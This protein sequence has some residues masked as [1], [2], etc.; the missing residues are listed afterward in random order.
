MFYSPSSLE[1]IL[2]VF[3][4]AQK[5]RAEV[6]VGQLGLY[7][8]IEINCYEVPGSTLKLRVFN[9]DETLLF[10]ILSH[11]L[12]H[13]EAQRSR[14]ICRSHL[15]VAKGFKP[16][17]NTTWGQDYRSAQHNG[18]IMGE[19]VWSP[20]CAP[21][22]LSVEGHVRVKDAVFAAG[23]SGNWNVSFFSSALQLSWA[24]VGTEHG[25]D[26]LTVKSFVYGL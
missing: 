23:S 20:R 26:N 15:S 10:L 6:N 5:H 3:T 13:S 7:I 14:G 1:Y 21:V 4:V 25:T 9:L 18:P 2:H 16:E 12:I 19:N 22:S 11:L 8:L 24:L 17:R